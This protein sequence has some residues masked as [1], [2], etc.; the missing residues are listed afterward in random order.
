MATTEQCKAFINK[1][2]PVVVKYA[3]IYGF[4]VASPIIAQACL[5]S[6]YGTT[7]LGASDTNNFFGMKAG[8]S[9]KGRVKRKQTQEQ[10]ADGS[11]I[12]IYSDFRAYDSVDEGIKGYF[13]FITGYTRYAKAPGQT[14]P[15]GYLQAIKDAGYATSLKYVDNNM[16]V[17]NK[18][19][20]T[21][22]DA[23]LNAPSDGVAVPTVKLGNKDENARLLQKNLN[24]VMEFD[25]P[26]TGTV[27]KLTE[28][29][30]IL[31]QYKYEL[32]PDGIYGKKSY[33]VM[34]ELIKEKQNV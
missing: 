13:D 12:T 22:Y 31:F 21:Q 28:A 30:L 1:V 16:N 14:T 20:L 23:Q 33:A 7:S 18:W 26:V 8:S 2:A 19:N 17:V 10:R 29:A 34:H 5:E 15:R 4:K 3:K 6:A 27:D 11:Y 24:E 25:I 9:W 32:D